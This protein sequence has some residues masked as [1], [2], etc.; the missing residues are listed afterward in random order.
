LRPLVLSGSALKRKTPSMSTNNPN[1]VAT[2]RL[3]QTNMMI[4]LIQAM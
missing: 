4:L 3:L 1:K 2:R